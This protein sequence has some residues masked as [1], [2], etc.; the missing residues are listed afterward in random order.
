MRRID[1]EIPDVCLIEPVV[2]GDHRGFFMES[3]NRHLFS[4][5]GIDCDFVQDNHSR[6]RTGV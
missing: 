1:T 5:I 4:E 2:Y 6:S 3:Y